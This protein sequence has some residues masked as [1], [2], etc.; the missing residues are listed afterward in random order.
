M[1]FDREIKQEARRQYFRYFRFWLIGAAVMLV[2]AI[3]VNAARAAVNNRTRGN[4]QAP[5]ERVYDDADVLTAE[6]ED[7]LRDYIAQLERTSHVDLI[8]VTIKEPMGSDD[9]IW[10]YNMMAYADDFYDNGV[11]GWNRAHGDGA[12]LLDNWY[13]DEYG[14][15][16]GSWLSTSGRMEELIGAYEENAVFDAMWNDMDENPYKGYRAAL[17]RLAGYGG[18]S[19]SG[20]GLGVLGAMVVSAVAAFVYAMTHLA[21]SKAKDT[22]TAATYV[23]SGRPTINVKSDDF[24]RKNVVSRRI[25]TSSGSGGGGSSHRGGGSYGSHHSSGGYSHGGGGRRR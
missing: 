3:G 16:K 20:R 9:D 6:E 11:Y 10:E 19:R 17:G 18:S 22:T 15:Q 2:I 1:D 8:L 5:S 4:D 14:S 13:E 23:N 25:E 21:Q 12:L 24:I 7:A